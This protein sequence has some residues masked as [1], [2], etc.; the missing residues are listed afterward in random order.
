VVHR[1]IKPENIL[2]SEGQALVADLGIA[3]A[4][5]GGGGGGGNETLT[6]A[7]MALGTP[8][9][10]SPEQASADAA[11]EAVAW[12]RPAGIGLSGR[13]DGRA[14]WELRQRSP[15]HLHGGQK[16]HVAYSAP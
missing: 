1:D 8:V 15:A 10:M 14:T 11:V 7:G 12:H 3:R 16:S 13:W 5:G 2:L 4:L 9:Y 6:Q